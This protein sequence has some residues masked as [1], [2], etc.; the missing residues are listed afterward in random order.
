MEYIG[1]LNAP[2]TEGGTRIV[3]ITSGCSHGD[4]TFCSIYDQDFQIL[5]LEIVRKQLAMIRDGWAK[6][7]PVKR[8][9]FAD[10]DPFVFN[11]EKLLQYFSLAREYLPNIEEFSMY[12]TVLNVLRKSEE[13]LKELHE[14]GLH[15]LHIGFESGTN[16]VLKD[17]NCGFT[18]EE[19]MIAAKKLHQAGIRFSG[20]FMLG[21]GGKGTQEKSAKDMA[22]LIDEIEPDLVSVNSFTIYEGS[23]IYKQVKSGDFIPMRESEILL[24]YKYLI[25]N[26]K[27]PIQLWGRHPNNT[28]QISG[29]IL[30]KKKYFVSRI[31]ESLE[32]LDDDL[33]DEKYN[34]VGKETSSNREQK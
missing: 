29:N 27:K 14:A 4:C 2:P 23:K 17:L 5:D 13:D 15:T 32:R 3:Q 16:Q 10:G 21:A 8:L 19:A 22:R 20:L 1:R 34:R 24:E 30:E 7:V 28:V 25:E 11:K 33:F 26:I 18:K 12:A 9:Y 6:K 31:E